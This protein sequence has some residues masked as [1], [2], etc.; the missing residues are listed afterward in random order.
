MTENKRP[1]SEQRQTEIIGNGSNRL[2]ARLLFGDALEAA[3]AVIFH[4]TERTTIVI[5]R[6]PGPGRSILP[7]E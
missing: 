3:G 1:Q 2:H 7:K 4:V 5:R 6:L